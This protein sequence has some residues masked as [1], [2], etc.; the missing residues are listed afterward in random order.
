MSTEVRPLS[1]ADLAFAHDLSRRA[2]WNQTRRDWERFLCLG[3]GGCFLA[4]EEGQSAG[5]AT[6]T[7]YGTELAW[8]GMVLVHPDFRRR[9]I[10][11]ELLRRAISYLREEREIA[12]VRLDATPEGRPLYEALG[13]EAEWDISRWQR[14]RRGD[15]KGSA[16]SAPSELGPAALALDHIV[17]GADRANLLKSLVEGSVLGV[18]HADG[19]F[20]LLREGMRASYLGPVTAASVRGGL[21]IAETLIRSCPEDHA[22][23]WD[24]PDKNFPAV[25]LAASLGFRPVR[26]L[27]RMRLGDR[28]TSCDP[29]GIFGLSEPGLG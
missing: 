26:R 7:C 28:A 21:E 3:Q 13:F 10:G 17:F 8:I 14:E 12:C 19:S 23:F 1:E 4:L 9:G 25:E 29:S 20:G 2:G 24:L 6:T 5:T 11:T 16:F 18:Q 27:T 22:V 15:L